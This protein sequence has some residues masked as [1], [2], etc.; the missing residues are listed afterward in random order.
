MDKQKKWEI[1][2]ELQIKNHELRTEKIVDILLA[3]R[4]I[5]TPE[6]KEQFIHPKL[7]E[8]TPESVGLDKKNITKAITRIKKAYDEKEQVAIF[9]DYDV[10]GITGTAILWETLYGMGMHVVPYI[11]HR[12]EEG[13]GLSIQGIKNLKSQISNV[14][15]IITVDNG[16][17]ANKAVEFANQQG[18]DVIIT[19]HHTPP[20]GEGKKLPDA[21]TI[22]HT[23]KLCGA[24]VA[25]LLGQEIS[26]FQDHAKKSHDGINESERSQDSPLLAQNDKLDLVCLGTIADLVPLTGA[27]RTLVKFGLDA[28]RNTNR[29]GLQALFQEAKIEPEKIGTYQIGHMI[30]PRLNAMG[31]LESAMD[32]LRLLCTKDRLRALALA[33]KLG[34]TNRERQIMTLRM[35]THAIESVKSKAGSVKDVL[36]VYDEIYDQGIIGL[37]AGRLVEE[38][39]RP[40]IVL[41]KGEKISKASARSISGFN[42][43]EFIR[44]HSHLLL[45]HGGHP[46]AAGFSVETE[47]LMVLQENLERVAKEQV[48]DAMLQRVLKVDMDLPVEWIDQQLYESIQQLSPFGMKNPEPLFVSKNLLVRDIRTIGMDNK[49]LKLRVGNAINFDAIAFGFGE[50]SKEIQLG[51]TIDMVYSIDENTWNGRTNLQLKVKDMKKVT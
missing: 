5:I 14:T 42:I 13:Y 31:R 25:Y 6:E 15:L 39:Y 16:I 38:F 22:V 29:F 35:T 33:E 30:A 36:F 10:D 1:L 19:D 27:N 28:L 50:M 24:G 49:H 46:M 3:N 51:D 23:T 21:L 8:V 11:P 4:G 20:T 40:A 17:V 47:K 37:I 32:S 26:N 12:V 9:G 48:T 44:A 7:E 18:I 43:I 41:S 34:L 2:S 45:E